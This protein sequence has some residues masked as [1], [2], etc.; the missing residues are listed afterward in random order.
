MP[1]Y[2]Q[3]YAH[4]KGRLEGRVFRWLPIMLNGIRLVFKRKLM[5]LLIGVALIPFMFRLGMVILYHNLDSLPENPPEHF[6]EEI[7]ATGNFYYLF[8]TREQVFGVIVMCLFMGAPLVARDMRVGAMEVY[9]AK[10]ITVGEYLL[11]KGGVVVSYVFLVTLVP[12]LLLYAISIGVSSYIWRQK[13]R[14][15]EKEPGDAQ[16]E[17]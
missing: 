10:P 13:R 9:F 16:E 8:L 3:S 14:K 5:L 6:G 15:K 17:N 12:A 7:R 4:W 1:I 11:G 2:D